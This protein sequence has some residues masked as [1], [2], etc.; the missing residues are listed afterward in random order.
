MQRT[1][2]GWGTLPRCEKSGRHSG[3]LPSAGEEFGEPDSGE[4]GEGTEV[5][6]DGKHE[7]LAAG[8]LPPAVAQVETGGEEE[9]SG[10]PPDV[11]RRLLYACVAEATNIRCL[12]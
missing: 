7:E 10:G 11:H 12:M 6:R 3:L 8:A 4:E 2:V 9:Q 1:T 5:D